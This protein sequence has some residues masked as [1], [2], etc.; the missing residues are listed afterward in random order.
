MT[1]TPFEVIAD[2]NRR[3]ILDLLRVR[4][5]AVGELVAE[6]SIAQPTVSKHLKV[7]KEA[8][9]VEVEQQAN[10][11]LYELRTEPLAELDRWLAPYRAL[12]EQRFDALERRLD[13]K[14]GKPPRKTSPRRKTR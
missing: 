13:A 9:L 2:P 3:Q 6:L 11:R 4:R 5:R 14:A 12:W 10:R 1:P 7:L 8:G